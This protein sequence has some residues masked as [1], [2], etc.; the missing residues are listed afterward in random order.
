MSHLFCLLLAST[1]SISLFSS[2][3]EKK[4]KD[5]KMFLTIKNVLSLLNVIVKLYPVRTLTQTA[6][7]ITT[8]IDPT[9]TWFQSISEILFEMLGSPSFNIKSTS[10]VSLG[11]LVQK[12]NT[13]S[14][15]Q[16]LCIRIRSLVMQNVVKKG[17]TDEI[18][19]YFFVCY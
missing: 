10:A 16:T 17:K 1:K 9:S 12:A 13:P 3:D 4:K 8:V 7:A 19:P 14:I 11:V 2:E 5:R 15:I 6:G 18:D